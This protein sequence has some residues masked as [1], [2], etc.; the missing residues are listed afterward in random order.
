MPGTAS[1]QTPKRQTL[2]QLESAI[3]SANDRHTR[4]AEKPDSSE[5]RDGEIRVGTHTWVHAGNRTEDFRQQSGLAC[6][7]EDA[8]EALDLL[9]PRQQRMKG[10]E[11]N[12]WNWMNML[13]DASCQQ[14]VAEHLLQEHANG[15]TAGTASG[16]LII[17]AQGLGMES[18]LKAAQLSERAGPFDLTHNL[19]QLFEGLSPELQAELTE[20]YRTTAPPEAKDAADLDLP[21]F[22]ADTAMRHVKARLASTRAVS[23]I[24]PDWPISRHRMDRAIKCLL[25]TQR[26]ANLAIRWPIPIK[27]LTKA[28]PYP[29]NC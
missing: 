13:S 15:S 22:L 16:W 18:G 28:H 10:P 23:E 17:T 6:S 12:D 4:R 24:E 14:I 21:S 5:R 25:R 20:L 26:F 8:K 9:F 7:W 2:E 27:D 29:G 19:S 11:L 1:S 3:A